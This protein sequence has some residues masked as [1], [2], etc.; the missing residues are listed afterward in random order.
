MKSYAGSTDAF[1]QSINSRYNE[2][3][4]SKA[5]VLEYAAEIEEISDQIKG[6]ES[7]RNYEIELQEVKSRLKEFSCG[8]A[9]YRIC[10]N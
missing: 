8:R 2:L 6:A 1:M 4:R 9:S 10:G 5:R 3:Y 7:V